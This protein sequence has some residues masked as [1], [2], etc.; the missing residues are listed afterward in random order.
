MNPLRE[1]RI[2]FFDFWA[3]NSNVFLN[4]LWV[5][6]AKN[7]NIMF[8][9]YNAGI[10]SGK[11]DEQLHGSFKNAKIFSFALEVNDILHK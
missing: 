2:A 8:L 11:V 4:M 9:N 5:E 10:F 3:K 1:V 7:K 6:F